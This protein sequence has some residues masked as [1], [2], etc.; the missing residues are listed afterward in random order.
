MRIDLGSRSM[1][2][3]VCLI[4]RPAVL[5]FVLCLGLAFATKLNPPPQLEFVANEHSSDM[6][7]VAHRPHDDGSSPHANGKNTSTA[8]TAATAAPGAQPEDTHSHLSSAEVIRLE[9][10][11][12]AH[13]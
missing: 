7:P 8:T 3:P 6:A 2:R 13:K 4:K 1:V 9:H 5:C 12:G 11:C 10:E